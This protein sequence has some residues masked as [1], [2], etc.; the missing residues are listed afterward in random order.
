MMNTT[1]WRRGIAAFS[2]LFLL[3]GCGGGGGGSPAATAPDPNPAPPPSS[4]AKT[5]TVG[6]MFTDGPTDRFDQFLAEIREIRL[7]GDSGDVTIF[8]I[9][10]GEPAEVIDF[11]QLGSF[12]ELFTVAE[13]VPAGDYDKIR[14]ILDDLTIVDLDTDPAEEYS[15]KLPGNGKVDLNPRGTFF[16]TPGSTLLVEIDVDAK[17]SLKVVEAGNSEKYLFRPVVFVKIGEEGSMEP[18]TKLTRIFGSVDSVSDTEDSF[19]LCQQARASDNDGDSDDDSDSDRGGDDRDNNKCVT[20]L[21][22]GE[23]GIFGT[24]GTP[25]LFGDVAV[26]EPLTAIGRLRTSDETPADDG[27]TDGDTDAGEGNDDGTGDDD[28]DTDA[29]SDGDTDGSED[30]AD[31]DSDTDSDSDSSFDDD[32]L[33]L[34]AYVIELGDMGTFE[35]LNGEITEDIDADGAFGL[36]IA[37]GQGFGDDT[38]VTG[39]YQ[40]GTGIFNKAGERLAREDLLRGQVGHF[41]GVIALSDDEPDAL[42]T[43]FIV[44]DPEGPVG[45]TIS[46]TIQTIDTEAGQFILTTGIGDTQVCVDDETTITLVTLTDDGSETAE[47]GLADLES[48]LKAEAFG[49]ASTDG[50]FEAESVRAEDDQRT[51]DANSPPVADA[52]DDDTVMVGASYMLDGSASSDPDGDDLTYS[53]SLQVPEGS[54]QTSLDDATLMNPVF[55]PDVAG[56]YVAELVV[57]DGTED[58][59][60]DSVTITASE[61]G[62]TGGGSQAPDGE[63]L[64]ADLCQACHKPLAE[65]EVAGATAGEIQSAIDQGRGGM[66]TTALKALTREEIEAI[67]SV[68]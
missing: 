33:I 43:S 17:K 16:V 1:S 14:L 7:L 5:G 64:Y 19:V 21:A 56:D 27:D 57:N 66:D 65:T 9:P 49:T 23:T 29:D 55:T 42:R 31:S 12:N 48:G 36:A 37:P 28:G 44:L 58:S 2:V 40:D 30:S 52:G 13:D 63:G 35:R 4:S 6:I 60:P 8:S 26:G 3:A 50:C 61:D 15:V 22:S 25:A 41:E 10:D 18:G 20:V 45:E 38:V 51:P 68:L 39:L 11:L 34:D 46:G 54:T 67:A 24:D 47:V 32:D 62:S 53:W 59:T